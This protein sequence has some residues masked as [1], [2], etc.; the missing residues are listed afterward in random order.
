MFNDS[1]VARMYACTSCGPGFE[2]RCGQ[3]IGFFCPEIIS[4][5]PEVKVG[6]VTFT[7]PSRRAGKAVDSAP[8]LLPAPSNCCLSGV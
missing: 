8:V 3:L 7:L 6:G 1:L 4:N 2:I 5:N